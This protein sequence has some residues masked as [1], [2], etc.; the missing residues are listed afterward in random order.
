MFSNARPTDTC[1][2][3]KHLIHLK[4][5]SK[6]SQ[7]QRGLGSADGEQRIKELN[8]DNTFT[9]SAMDDIS[10]VLAPP[11]TQQQP[12]SPF[13]FFSSTGSSSASFDSVNPVAGLGVGDEQQQYATLLANMTGDLFSDSSSPRSGMKRPAESVEAGGEPMDEHQAKRGRFDG[14][15]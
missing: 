7:T 15:K 12:S 8:A 3:Q 9:Q 10:R 1:F 6:L 13:S 5:M 4:A 2:R 14:P 11:S